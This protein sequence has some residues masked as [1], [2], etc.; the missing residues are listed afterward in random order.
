MKLIIKLRGTAMGL[1]MGGL[2][3]FYFGAFLCVAFLATD[4]ASVLNCVGGEVHL[5]AVGKVHFL[6]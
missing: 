4:T 3:G 1:G 5:Q 6:P 2:T